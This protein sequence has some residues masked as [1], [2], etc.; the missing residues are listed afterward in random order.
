MNKPF[1]TRLPDE[2]RAELQK[3]AHAKGLTE[4]DLGRMYLVEKLHEASANEPRKLAAIVIA[5]LSETITFEQATELIDQFFDT[6][7]KVSS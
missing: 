4:S 6:E 5:A 1:S 2:V 7:G 3:Q